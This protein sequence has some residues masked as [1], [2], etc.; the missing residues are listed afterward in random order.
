[1]AKPFQVDGF[2]VATDGRTIVAAEA[3]D[4]GLPTP[5]PKANARKDGKGSLAETTRH[6][7][8]LPA[9]VGIVEIDRATL[10][11]WAAL[12]G[13]A[14]DCRWCKGAMVVPHAC[15]CGLCKVETEPCS[16]QEFLPGM[17]LGGLVDRRRLA[18]VLAAAPA[19]PSNRVFAHRITGSALRVWDADWRAVLGWVEQTDENRAAAVVFEGHP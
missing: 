9:E 15:D 8:T 2:A 3:H 6:Y 19:S 17:I 1:M 13:P 10:A 5:D 11:A 7:L 4:A 18:K 14:A 16:C 12:P